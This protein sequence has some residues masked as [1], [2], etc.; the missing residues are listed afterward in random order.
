[1]EDKHTKGNKRDTTLYIVGGVAISAVIAGVL[2]AV[3]SKRKGGNSGT[4]DNAFQFHKD[5]ADKDPVRRREL[6]GKSKVITIK[7]ETGELVGEE[8]ANARCEKLLQ[9]VK[10]MTNNSGGDEWRFKVCES[11]VLAIAE[12][13]YSD[14]QI[15]RFINSNERNKDR[16]LEAFKTF[17]NSV[18]SIQGIATA[19]K[20]AGMSCTSYV[21]D[22][23][24]SEHID[25]SWRSKTTTE[26]WSLGPGGVIGTILGG[27]KI[28]KEKTVTEV[29]HNDIHDS[30]T[31]PIFKCSNQEITESV[32]LALSES[33]RN[34][35]TV[36][37]TAYFDYMKSFPS[38]A[39]SFGIT[40][41]QIERRLKADEIKYQ[42][43]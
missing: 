27:P 21:I 26:T 12:L 17:Q 30:N 15:D 42:A 1:M 22:Y 43:D 4:S 10:A 41:S 8:K 34:A 6:I 16:G 37:A 38:A 31:V 9:T 33:E 24:H 13:A 39:E 25:Q 11:T 29:F 20:I 18:V 40:K 36:A 2:I 23:A 3:L 32:D 14:R 35:Y 5:M 28:S 7:G 19:A